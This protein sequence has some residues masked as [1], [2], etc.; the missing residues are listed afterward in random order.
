MCKLIQ[1]DEGKKPKSNRTLIYVVIAIIPL[2]IFGLLFLMS[3][4]Q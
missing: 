4:N 1:K 3:R 2:L